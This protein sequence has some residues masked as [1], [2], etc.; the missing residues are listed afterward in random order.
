[1]NTQRLRGE[2]V[3]QY[4]SQYRFAK[5]LG[6]HQNKLSRLMTGKYI[7]NINEVADISHKLNLD[8][9]MHLK[10]FLDKTTPNG[11]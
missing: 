6:W 3:S 10:I 1:M 2:V 9:N 4:G 11:E 5:A 8:D 7:P